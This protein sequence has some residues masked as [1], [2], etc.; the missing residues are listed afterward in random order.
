MA[1]GDEHSEEF[2]VYG[3]PRSRAYLLIAGGVGLALFAVAGFF[4][5]LRSNP[6]AFGLQAMT[7]LPMMGAI[8]LFAAAW[9]VL[10]LPQ[11]VDLDDG[12]IR[13]TARSG[14]VGSWSW[15]DIAFVE[16]GQ[17][18]SGTRQLSIYGLNGRRLAR[19]SNRF[20]NFE[21][22]VQSIQRRMADRASPSRVQAE[23]RKHRK[24]GALLMFGGVV[25][26]IMAGV[27]VWMAL[28]DREAQRLLSERGVPAMATVVEKFIAPD[29]RTHRIMYRVDHV[30]AD[31][32]PANVEIEPALWTTLDEGTPINVVAVP[33]R[34]DISRLAVGQIDDNF[35]PKPEIMLLVCAAVAVMGIVFFV[36]GVLSWIGIEIKF[37][38]E[39]GFRVRRI[40]QTALRTK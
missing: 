20:D 16:T 40:R 14:K 27:N 37:D 34:P 21:V 2:A 19:L 12:G 22:M 36:G 7:T 11:H 28:S 35:T 31:S 17:D 9:R 30:P 32:T 1:S 4:V 23:R 6:S 39:F 33:G 15:D 5:A 10:S 29:G 25:A 13:I 3:D 8:G 18:F 26:W 38:S 24:T